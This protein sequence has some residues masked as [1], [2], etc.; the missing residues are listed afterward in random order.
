MGC[1]KEVNVQMKGVQQAIANDE[2]EKNV[3]PISMK[4]STDRDSVIRSESFCV[5]NHHHHTARSSSPVFNDLI[6]SNEKP[7]MPQV[8]TAKLSARRSA[9]TYSY[10]GISNVDRDAALGAVLHEK[11]LHFWAGPLTPPQSPR[12]LFGVIWFAH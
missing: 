7:E 12:A 6:F 10:L 1:R 4:S 9:G 2:C 11:P 3:A 5:P 8:R